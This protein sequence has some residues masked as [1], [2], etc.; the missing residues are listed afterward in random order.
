MLISSIFSFSTVFSTLSKREIT[1]LT[2]FNL[3][4]ANAFNLVTSKFLLFGKGFKK[5]RKPLLFLANAS[6][7][8]LASRLCP[9][10]IGSTYSISKSICLPRQPGCALKNVKSTLYHTIRGFKNPQEEHLLYIL[11]EKKNKLASTKT[12]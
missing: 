10:P 11:W 4:S 9:R 8:L 5:D 6:S 3:S 2:M 7:L 1:I 12:L